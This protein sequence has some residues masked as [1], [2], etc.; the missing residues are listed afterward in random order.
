MSLYQKQF[1]KHK[2]SMPVLAQIIE[3]DNKILDLQEKLVELEYDIVMP[4]T[5]LRATREHY[6]EWVEKLYNDKH[7]LLIKY[8]EFLKELHPTA[9]E[10]I[11]SRNNAKILNT[12]NQ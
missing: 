11:I 9:I 1:D 10:T 12:L 3:I 8:H 7:L 4:K 5:V 2:E 6:S